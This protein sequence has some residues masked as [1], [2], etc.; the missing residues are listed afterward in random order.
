VL[1]A[2][3]DDFYRALM[4]AS[5]VRGMFSLIPSTSGAV[6]RVSDEENDCLMLSFTNTEMDA[7]L[8]N[9]KVDTAPGLDGRPVVFFTKF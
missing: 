5:R 8:S 2:H 1:K 3:I 4:G 6:G 9:M 7:V